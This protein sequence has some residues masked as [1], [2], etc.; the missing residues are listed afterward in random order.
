MNGTLEY[1]K[2]DPL[3]TQLSSA[4][5]TRYPFGSIPFLRPHRKININLLNN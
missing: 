5:T 3:L 4:V 2:L 1:T